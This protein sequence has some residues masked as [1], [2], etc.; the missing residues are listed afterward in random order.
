MW[1][2]GDHSSTAVRVVGASGWR[3]R[4]A[5]LLIRRRRHCRGMHLQEPSALPPQWML[6]Q[7]RTRLQA[8]KVSADEWPK[9]GGKLR[10]GT[11]FTA[12]RACITAARVLTVQGSGGRCLLAAHCFVWWPGPHAR[13]VQGWWAAWPAGRGMERWRGAPVRL[14]GAQQTGGARG[15]GVVVETGRRRARGGLVDWGDDDEASTALV[16]ITTLAL[17][18]P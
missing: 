18:R 4:R 1:V 13:C 3:M 5:T 16:R 15:S 14:P 7:T 11:Q 9:G 8:S 10:V 2:W 17:D 6:Y 12:T